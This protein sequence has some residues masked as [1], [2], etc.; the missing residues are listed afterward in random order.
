MLSSVGKK[1]IR[2]YCE[3]LNFHDIRRKK[4]FV[5]LFSGRLRVRSQQNGSFLFDTVCL[6]LIHRRRIHWRI[7][8]CQIVPSLSHSS[9]PSNLNFPAQISNSP[10]PTNFNIFDRERKVFDVWIQSRLKFRLNFESTEHLSEFFVVLLGRLHFY[11]AG[12]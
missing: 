5:S 6:M 4:H 12:N 1:R 10:M 11:I 9:S 3:T 2:C 8:L 7:W